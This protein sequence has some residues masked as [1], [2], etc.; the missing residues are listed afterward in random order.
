MQRLGSIHYL[1]CTALG[2]YAEQYPADQDW[3]TCLELELNQAE[4]CGGLSFHVVVLF[5]FDVTMQQGHH[6]T[7]YA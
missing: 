4:E 7:E 1:S 2:N 5:G 6:S 3:A